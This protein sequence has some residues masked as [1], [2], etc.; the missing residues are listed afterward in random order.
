MFARHLLKVAR[1]AARSSVV[2]KSGFNGTIAAMST[3]RVTIEQA[4]LMAKNYDEMPNDILLSMAISGDQE[5]REERLIREI[6]SVDNISWEKAEEKFLVIVNA[7][8]QG[9][10]MAT[11]PYKIGIFSAV[12]VAVASIPMIFELNTVLWFNELYVTSGKVNF[13]RLLEIFPVH[14]FL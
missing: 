1:T 11:L 5:A 7:N 8:R 4:K 2:G 9:L 6:M 12:T 14:N 10:F 3:K 13:K